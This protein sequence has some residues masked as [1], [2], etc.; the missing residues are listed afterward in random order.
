MSLKPPGQT[1]TPTTADDA[2]DDNFDRLDLTIRFSASLPDLLL[3]LPN[4]GPANAATLKQLIR[5]R[6]PAE[7]ARHRIRLIHAGKALVDDVPLN[8]ALNRHV[9]RPP[10][11]IGTPRPYEED[12]KG[13]GKTPVR[14]DGRK[15]AAR[16]YIH[17]SIG[18]V[19][20]STAELAA[21]AALAQQE[22]T[23]ETP[24]IAPLFSAT[25]TTPAPRGFDRLLHSGFTAA[26]VQSLRLQFL[27]IQAHTHTP[28]TMPSPATLRD[29]EDRWLDDSTTDG[30][31]DTMGGGVDGAVTASG[32]DDQTGA[33]D[34]MVLGTAMGF[35]W[36]VGC[37]MW[38]V[39]EE[40]IWSQRRKMAVVVG[41]LL[42]VGLGLIR[43][44]G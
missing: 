36:P 4:P 27:A 23:E 43:Y 14:D 11:R 5:S 34:D 32:G 40:G 18:D 10:S 1:S 30:V 3:S 28:D 2:S 7:Y 6:I 21:E 17:C 9:S 39:R 38:G 13:K 19:V 44:T 22:Q 25:T 42:N 26:E 15:S 24:T 20:L 35:F 12:G 8:V 37:L 29:L 33:L 31:A 41:F 16:L